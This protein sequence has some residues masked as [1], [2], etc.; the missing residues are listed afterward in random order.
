MVLLQF[1][2]RQLGV[3]CWAGSADIHV[4]LMGKPI[5]NLAFRR[6]HLRAA[7][8]PALMGNGAAYTIGHHAIGD[9]DGL[10]GVLTGQVSGRVVVW[11]G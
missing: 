10:A 11:G 9:H 1:I 3:S 5:S 2:R 7:F 6:Q 4:G 8:G